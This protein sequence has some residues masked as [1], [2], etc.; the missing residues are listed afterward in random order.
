MAVFSPPQCTKLRNKTGEVSLLLPTIT[1]TSRPRR[2][3]SRRRNKSRSQ[4]IWPRGCADPGVLVTFNNTTRPTDEAFVRK[5]FIVRRGGGLGTA[6]WDQRADDRFWTNTR[7]VGNLFIWSQLF[8][9]ELGV[10]WIM[11]NPLTS[12]LSL[13]CRHQNLQYLEHLHQ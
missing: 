13:L 8:T 3:P 12:P 6:A 7:R 11:S 5:P 1:Q 2:N 9:S 10:D 4:P